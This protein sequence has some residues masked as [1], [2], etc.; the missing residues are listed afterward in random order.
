MRESQRLNGLL[1]DFLEY[2]RPV[3]PFFKELRVD[4]LAEE[5]MVQMEQTCP[6]GV[7]LQLSAEEPVSAWAD[8]E[9]LKQVIWNLAMNGIEA[10]PSG[11]ELEV[12]IRQG[13]AESRA[14]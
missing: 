7:A 3:S 13:E 2:S 4:Q 10:M 5:L 1:A 12:V 14:S 8:S 11:G 6:D 9:Q